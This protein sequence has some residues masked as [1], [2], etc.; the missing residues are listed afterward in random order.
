MPKDKRISKDQTA[1]D[2]G[3]DDYDWEWLRAF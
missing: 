2:E 3:E 1:E